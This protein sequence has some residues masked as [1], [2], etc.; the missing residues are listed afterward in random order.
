MHKLGALAVLGAAAQIAFCGVAIAG[1]GIGP[2]SVFSD[3]AAPGP[4]GA[5][6]FVGGMGGSGGG[7]GGG[8]G[9]MGGGAGGMGGVSGGM[10]GGHFGFS[11]PFG[12]PPIVLCD[13]L[14]I[15]Q[16]VPG[17]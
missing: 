8:A 6:V 11:D 17:R 14:K 12:S 5:V 13:R 10:G 15:S 16:N 1:P 9:G 2:S 3:A 4:D 7:M